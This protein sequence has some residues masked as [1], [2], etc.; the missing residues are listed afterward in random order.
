MGRMDTYTIECGLQAQHGNFSAAYQSNH[1]YHIRTRTWPPRLED[2]TI[3]GVAVQLVRM[4]QYNAYRYW[5]ITCPKFH[6]VHVTCVV[7]SVFFGNFIN[8]L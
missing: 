6:C 4:P 7:N 5:R 8:S 2:V 3:R 1:A